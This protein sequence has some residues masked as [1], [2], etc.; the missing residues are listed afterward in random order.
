M[1]DRSRVQ[2]FNPA[3]LLAGMQWLHRDPALFP[4]AEWHWKDTKTESYVF[5]THAA[6][7]IQAGKM[8]YR[9]AGVERELMPV[10]VVIGSPQ[11]DED[12]ATRHRQRDEAIEAS[13]ERMRVSPE[14]A[15]AA[16]EKRHLD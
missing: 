2:R 11:L 16:L 4:E 12:R 13:V 8:P 3:G 7:E 10:A 14:E 5:A 6:A 15:Y 1:S 9:V